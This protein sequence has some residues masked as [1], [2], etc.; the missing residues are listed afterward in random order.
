MWHNIWQQGCK[1]THTSLIILSTCTEMCCAH[2]TLQPLL[3]LL[4]TFLVCR[5][6]PLYWILPE[7]TTYVDDTVT[8][9]MHSY[10]NKTYIK[11]GTAEH[12]CYQKMLLHASK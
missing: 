6:I 10:H 11:D 3:K 2:Y 8:V 4:H 9:I 12:K 7:L 5:L 1:D